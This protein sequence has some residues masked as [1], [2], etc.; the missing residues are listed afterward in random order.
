MVVV[1]VMGCNS[2]GVSGGEEGQAKKGDGSVI[3]LKVVGEKIKSA[4][5]FVEK[6]KE[7]HTLVKSV[8]ELAKAIGKKVGAAGLGDIADHN[9]SL[10][11]G[12]YSV[13]EAVDAKLATLAGKVG[14]SSD[15]ST[16]VNDAKVKST[17]FLNKLK[18]S[19]AEFDKEG[20]S[21]ADSKKALLKD[22]ADKTKGRDELDKLNTSIDIL[23]ASSKKELDDSIKNLIEEPVRP[24]TVGN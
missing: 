12:A 24:D 20:A 16:K 18:S 21:D 2:G 8:D 15:L 9:G 10:I 7:V 1:M 5:E 11:A 23:M 22:N 19:T 6:V 14:L 4:V 13:I 3:D 17:A